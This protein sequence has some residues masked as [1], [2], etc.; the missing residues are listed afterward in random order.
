MIESAFPGGSEGGTVET[1]TAGTGISVDSTNPA[2]PIITNTSLNT[3]EVAKVSSNDTTAGFLNGKLVAGLNVTFTENNN[4]GNETLTIAA[5]VPVTSVNTKTGAVTLTN[6]DV[7]AAATVHTHAAADV[8]SGV[9]ETARMANSGTASNATFL[10]GDR[11]WAAAPVTS[12]NNQTGAVTVDTERIFTTACLDAENTNALVNIVSV[13]VP[14]GSGA[15]PNN[16]LLWIDFMYHVRN[17]S[18][19][20][21]LLQVGI[22]V[23]GTS[24]GSSGTNVPTGT[25]YYGRVRQYLF[26]DASGIRFLPHGQNAQEINYGGPNLQINS[27]QYW[28]QVIWQTYNPGGGSFVFRFTAQ[29]ATANASSFVRILNARSYLQPGQVT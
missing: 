18:G 1:I 19:S 23:G 11:T 17:N 26:V 3:D 15:I 12:V 2:N 24:Y 16:Q 4:G 7:G 28:N 29:W 22:N 27:P 21:N 8:T 14:G 25:D 20:T 10:R 9:F 6:T 13:T 5:T